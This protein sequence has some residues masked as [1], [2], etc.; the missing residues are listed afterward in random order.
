MWI[1]GQPANR[2]ITRSTV[3]A[4]VEGPLVG[5]VLAHPEGVETC[6]FGTGTGSEDGGVAIAESG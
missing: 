1:A 5:V 2:G 3:A 6:R 4:T